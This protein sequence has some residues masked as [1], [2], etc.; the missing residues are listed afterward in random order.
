MG[1][2]YSLSGVQNVLSLHVIML[3]QYKYIMLN[4]SRDNTL[5]LYSFCFMLH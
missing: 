2:E 1:L 3:N 4:L 5:H